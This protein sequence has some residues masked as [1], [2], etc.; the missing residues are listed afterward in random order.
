MKELNKLVVAIYARAAMD[1]RETGASDLSVAASKV[2]NNIRHGR[3]VDPVEDIPAEYIPDWAALHAQEEAM[4]D[5]WVDA[6][7]AMNTRRQH[8]HANL[9]HL[10]ASGDYAGMVALMDEAS[11]SVAE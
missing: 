10:W 1:R 2:R 9:S 7:V 5:A 6:W 3:A 4:G 8:L 11:A